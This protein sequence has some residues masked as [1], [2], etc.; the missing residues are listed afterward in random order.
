VQ[1]NR[2]LLWVVSVVLLCSGLV[3]LGYEERNLK[4]AQ[5]ATEQTVRRTNESLSAEI[6]RSKQLMEELE[7]ERKQRQR[8][9][10]LLAQL[11]NK[12][13]TRITPAT[14]ERSGNSDLAT[15]R[16]STSQI[17]IQLVL[18]TDRRY[19]NYSVVITT[20]EGRPVW[21]NSSLTSH[22]VKQGKVTVVLANKMLSYDDYKIELRGAPANGDFEHLADYAFRFRR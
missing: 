3:Y 9:E 4:M 2:R 11:Q 7:S 15:L 1:R 5:T 19:E 20:F 16:G 22:N 18:D 21:N 14:F 17:R 12:A 10:D 8:A 13:T 6:N